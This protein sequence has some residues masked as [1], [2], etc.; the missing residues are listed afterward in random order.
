MN[1]DLYKHAVWRPPFK[2]WIDDRN[3]ISIRKLQENGLSNP[4]YKYNDINEMY[5]QWTRNRAS[6]RKGETE[7]G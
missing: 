1:A 6:K 5:R 2:K 3:F 7:K 4:R